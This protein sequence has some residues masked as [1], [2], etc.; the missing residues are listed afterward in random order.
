MHRALQRVIPLSLAALLAACAESAPSAPIDVSPPPA[1]TPAITV[2]AMTCIATVQS[3][4]VRCGVASD[5]AYR[6]SGSPRAAISALIVG[7]QARYFDLHPSNVQL[8]DETHEYSL[9][10]SVENLIPQPMGTADG[11]T[12][13]SDGVRALLPVPPVAIVLTD[14]A[15]ASTV[16]TLSPDGVSTFTASNQAYFE[17][18]GARLG[19]DELL[20][21][22]ETSA[23]KTWTFKIDPNVQVFA[24]VV[25]VSTVV[26][27]PDGFVE[28]GASDPFS[29]AGA[30]H[31]M[32]G[33]ARSAVGDEISGA[34]L[35][36]TSSDTAVATVDDATGMMTALAPGVAT[37]S[38]TS[39]RRRWRARGAPMGSSSRSSRPV[40]ARRDCM[41]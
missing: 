23:A 27:Y 40:Q 12:G 39:A 20:S 19:S 28:V 24:F 13:T 11:A 21:T 5:S 26:P 6:A 31:Q 33:V 17:Y 14:P 38:A 10:V 36:W 4:E 37:I 30:T 7:G 16:T 32:T 34:S 29:L 3:R 15:G 25:Y 8:D 2:Q 9:D 18:S 35:E 41:Y 1:A 22:N